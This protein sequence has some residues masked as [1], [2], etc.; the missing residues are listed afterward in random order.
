MSVEFNP[1]STSIPEK[2]FTEYVL[3]TA[4]PEPDLPQAD[5]EANAE[6]PQVRAV[7]NRVSAA[8]ES[9]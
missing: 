6:G 5:E 1:F 4:L 8:A 9:V 3:S 7:A 2:E